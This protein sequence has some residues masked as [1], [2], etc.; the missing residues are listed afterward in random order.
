MDDIYR[1]EVVYPDGEVSYFDVSLRAVDGG[2]ADQAVKD[3]VTA[4]LQQHDVISV[5]AYKRIYSDMK[6]L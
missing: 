2:D 1:L 5:T 6:V 3:S 4:I